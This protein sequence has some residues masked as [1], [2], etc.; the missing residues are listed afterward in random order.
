VIK[1][2]IFCGRYFQPD[3]RVGLKQKACFRPSCKRARKQPAQNNWFR[4]NPDYY[5]GRYGYVKQ[6]RQRRKESALQAQGQMIQDEM[7][8]GGH[9]LLCSE[10]R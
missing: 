3:P 6:W 10:R 1:R 8:M 4:R 9:F 7:E 2:F 5:R